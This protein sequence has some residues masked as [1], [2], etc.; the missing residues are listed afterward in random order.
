MDMTSP[1]L[2]FEIQVFSLHWALHHFHSFH[3][4]KQLFGFSL[5]ARRIHAAVYHLPGIF[6]ASHKFLPERF[7]RLLHP[8][9]SD[10]P[11]FLATN[12]S[13][14]G[15]NIFPDIVPLTGNYP[16]NDDPSN[17]SVSS[18]RDTRPPMTREKHSVLH[19]RD[20]KKVPPLERSESPV[21]DKELRQYA[22]RFDLDTNVVQLI[23]AEERAAWNPPPRAVAIYNVMLS[24]GLT[25]PLHPFI[26]CFLAKACISPAQLA[27]NS[28][29]ILM[30]MWRIRHRL[31]L[32]APN[33]GEI[34]HFYT[35]R[36][37]GHSGTF[38]LLSM[39]DTD[40][41]SDLQARRAKAIT[42]ASHQDAVRQEATR[43]KTSTKSSTPVEIEKGK[44][45]VA[46]TS[47]AP[48]R[49]NSP[50]EV[51]IED[52]SAD[53]ITLRKYE[54]RKATDL[55]GHPAPRVP[56]VVSF[57]DSSSSGGMQADAGVAD[58]PEAR[59]EESTAEQRA[60]PE[61]A[62]E[63]NRGALGDQAPTPLSC[64]QE[65]SPVRVP[66]NPTVSVL[67]ATPS[68]GARGSPT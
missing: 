16:S 39:Y 18:Y 17:P 51:E 5:L 55:M 58:T 64:R 49:I 47:A 63:A 14:F 30:W 33:P 65:S 12:V 52:P 62:G 25:L 56:R 8:Q 66:A 6:P 7:K 3:F 11:H 31:G 61:S 1:R 59:R 37:L 68:L 21:K 50:V 9:S 57:I 26:A 29:G 48:P 53:L 45:K 10:Q 34:R 46:E 27:S 13:E 2:D 28:Y 15:I 19:A 4:F 41:V 32:P 54:K 42:E 60:E 35:L 22:G 67:P 38:F 23:P 36:Q 20:Y 40:I 44:G 24:F 43:A